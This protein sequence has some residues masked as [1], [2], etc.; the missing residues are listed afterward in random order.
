MSE[1][2]KSRSRTMRAVKGKD[3]TPEMIVRHLVHSMGFRYRLHDN[4]LPGKP[5]LVFP[6]RRKVILVN[7]CFW[8]GHNCK[9]GGRVPKNNRDYWVRK[10]ENNQAR[11]KRTISALEA[12]GWKSAVLW[13]CQLRDQT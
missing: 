10:V 3:T 9:R 1:D 5:D 4:N 6:R 2:P 11:D 12:L 7:G 13:E 8:H